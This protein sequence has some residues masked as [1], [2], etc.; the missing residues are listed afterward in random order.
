VRVN[1]PSG[2]ATVVVY[3]VRAAVTSTGSPDDTA[4]ADADCSV[5]AAADASA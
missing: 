2:F 3:S 1:V 5:S 4:R